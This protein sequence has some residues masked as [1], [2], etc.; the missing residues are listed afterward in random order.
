[1]R[2]LL[3]EGALMRS[4]ALGAIRLYQ[5]AVS[6]HLRSV[7]RHSPTCSQYVYEAVSRYGVAKGVWV[8]LRRLSRCRPWGTSGYDPVP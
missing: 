6:P 4:L 7:C 8:G 2:R 3:I 5:A 1:M